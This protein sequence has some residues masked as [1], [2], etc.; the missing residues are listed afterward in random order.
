[1]LRAIE[2]FDIW[3]FYLINR[4]GKNIIFDYFMPFI[5]NERNFIIPI[6]IAWFYLVLKKSAKHR[7]VAIGIIALIGVSEFLCTDVFKPAFDRLR[8]YEAISEVHLNRG[9]LDSWHTTGVIVERQGNSLSLP[10][11][12]ATNIFA[13][14]LFLSYYFRRLWPFFFSIAVAVA[15]SRVYLGVHFP[16]DVAAGAV[17]GTLC[18]IGFIWVTNRVLRMWTTLFNSKPKEMESTIEKAP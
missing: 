10:S 4:S 16:L 13:A 18:A 6:A 3:L 15:Y 7:A 17:L 12:H 1:M 2:Q 5:S 14:A 11:A 8:P 9:R